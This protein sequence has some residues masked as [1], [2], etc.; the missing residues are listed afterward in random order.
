MIFWLADKKTSDYESGSSHVL[1]KLP[2]LLC[3][4]ERINRVPHHC[5]CGRKW[6][7]PPMS[8]LNRLPSD[9]KREQGDHETNDLEQ[10]M[11]IAETPIMATIAPSRPGASATRRK[12][13]GLFARADLFTASHQQFWVVFGNRVGVAWLS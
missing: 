13:V 4:C 7:P 1:Q 8:R 12:V 9:D 6:Q 2:D 3:K 5:D 10:F 11:A